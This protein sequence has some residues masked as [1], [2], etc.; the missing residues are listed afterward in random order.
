MDTPNPAQPPPIP[1]FSQ[2]EQGD[3]T[4]GLIPYK[5]PYAL[6]AYYTGIFS[7]IP[8]LGFIL[9]L[10]AVPLGIIGL[11]QRKKRPVISG[12]VH[13]W[14]GIVCGSFSLLAHLGVV[15]AF[16]FLAKGQHH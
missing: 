9:S 15:A 14:V 13:A 3:S 12:A 10:I 8:L 5:N 16:V 2:P 7:L 6:V 11:R 1:N 4:G